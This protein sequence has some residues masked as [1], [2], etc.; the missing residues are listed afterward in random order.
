V[1]RRLTLSC[2]LASF[3]SWARSD[4]FWVFCV[5]L[6]YSSL[7]VYVWVF[8]DGV[9]ILNGSPK[10]MKSCEVAAFLIASCIVFHFF[11]IQAFLFSRISVASG[12]SRGRMMRSVVV[13]NS[14]LGYFTSRCKRCDLNSKVF[15]NSL[16][17][18]T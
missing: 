17:M 12:I 15:I 7:E 9:F 6:N 10:I 3:L 8:C 1:K 5:H 14:N 16:R 2:F 13:L 18:K 11:C 4:H